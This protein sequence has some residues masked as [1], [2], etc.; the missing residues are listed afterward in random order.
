[1]FSINHIQFIEFLPEIDYTV[2]YAVLVLP[3]T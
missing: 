2:S 3:L 1:M